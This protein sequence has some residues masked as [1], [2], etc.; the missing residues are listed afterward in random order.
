ME[1]VELALDIAERRG[2]AEVFCQAINTK[3]LMLGARGR[4]E[5]G[6][7]LIR[8]ALERAIAADLHETVLR[9]YNNLAADLQSSD[10]L[11]ASS[12]VQSGVALSRRLGR[13]RLESMLTIG[14]MPV[15]VDLGR[16]DAAMDIV[17]DFLASPELWVTKSEI[18]SEVVF[19]V[20]IHLWRG[21]IAEARQLVERMA[22]L[23]VRAGPEAQL[24]HDAARAAVLRAQGRES[25][26]MTVLA[27]A[28]ERTT[29]A[30]DFLDVTR[31]LSIE[32]V[33]GAFLAG[34]HQRVHREL[35]TRVQ[36]SLPDS[37]TNPARPFSAIRSASGR[38][39]E[40]G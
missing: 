7:A 13:R 20:W 32:T 30:A 35:E 31:W 39:R 11:Q 3:G 21:Q 5:E 17:S 24:M 10:P 8:C 38:P 14:E 15:L 18:G 26:A 33:E 9:A 22:D 27:D 34:D 19:G 6:R 29:E 36:A 12:Y 23:C 16:W 37:C 4:R 40:S 28:T 2:D 1:R 25:E